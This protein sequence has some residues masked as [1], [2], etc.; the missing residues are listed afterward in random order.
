MQKNQSAQVKVK[1]TTEEEA[2]GDLLGFG[3]DQEIDQ[4]LRDADEVR[5]SIL[6]SS[7]SNKLERGHR[8]LDLVMV[9]LAHQFRSILIS[10]P[11]ISG[12]DDSSTDSS[13]SS[14][15]TSFRISF[16][17]ACTS[18]LPVGQADYDD[19][20]DDDDTVAAPLEN[21]HQF[22]IGYSSIITNLTPVRR[23]LTISNA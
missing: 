15:R 18:L 20:D 17:E 8:E 19:Y 2:C 5:Q 22:Q 14:E 12:A 4:C 9:R 21:L 11:S 3:D 7:G 13:F 6:W 10:L 1:M 23:Q 16:S